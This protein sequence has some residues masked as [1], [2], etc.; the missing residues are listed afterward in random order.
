M[1]IKNCQENKLPGYKWGDKGKCYT[2]DPKD[3]TARK[4]AYEKVLKQMKA[5]KAS[6]HK[7]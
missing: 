7:K 1:P 5:I 6:Q 2:Y 3:E 4:A